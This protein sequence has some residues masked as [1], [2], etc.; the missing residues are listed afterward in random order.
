M[1]NVTRDEIVLVVDDSPEALALINDTLE[2]E[3]IDVLVALE[4]Q[5]ALTIAKRVRPDMILLDAVMPRMDGFETC[6]HL[7]ND[8]DLS[9]IPVIFMTG[10]SD[11]KDIVKGLEVGGV[12]YLTKPIRPDELLARMRVHLKNARIADS[13]QRALD[14]TGQYLFSV[15][16]A[17]EIQWA[18]PQAYELLQQC[19]PDEHWQNDIFCKTIFQWLQH[20]PTPRQRSAFKDVSPPIA[21]E[22]VEARNHD[23]YL[24]KLINLDQIPDEVLLQ[25]NLNLT[26]REAEV[27]R[28]ISQGKTNREIGQ[29]LDISPRTV[30]KHLEQVFEKIG[31]ENRTTAASVAI[32]VITEH[33]H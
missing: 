24:L 26:K 21:V 27:L 16:T 18:T 30:N 32:R 9:G 17:G 5:Q 22:F 28:W 8:P 4:G 2:S 13:T 19:Q 3:N 14:N 12:D 23:E 25:K 10:L 7:K 6:Q 29:I 1:N 31:V 11:T 33:Q 15:T 20:H